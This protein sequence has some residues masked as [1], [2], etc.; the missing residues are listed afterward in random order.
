MSIEPII[1][2]DTDLLF[3]ILPSSVLINLTLP[4]AYI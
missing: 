4:F 1:F 2:N 3:Y